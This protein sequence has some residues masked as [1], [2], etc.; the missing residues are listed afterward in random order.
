[1]A[2][3]YVPPHLRNKAPASSG[4]S[5]PSR[6]PQSGSDSRPSNAQ[7]PYRSTHSSD[8]GSYGS[9]SARSNGQ[10]S[11]QHPHHPRD[12]RDSPTSPSY[13]STPSRGGPPSAGPRSGVALCV[14]G[15]S[16]GGPFKLLS[17]SSVKVQ[18][19]K[20]ASAKVC[21]VSTGHY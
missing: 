10:S 12:S 8:N 9:Y 15:D 18:T 1:M 3:R 6:Q 20:G 14:F 19:F 21:G 2:G 17:D 16:F 4:P 7:S 13:R 5:T 11:Y